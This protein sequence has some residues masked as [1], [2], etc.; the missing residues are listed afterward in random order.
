VRPPGAATRRRRFCYRRDITGYQRSER[1]PVFLRLPHAEAQRLD[2]ASR[3]LGT[4]KNRLIAD[5]VAAHLAADDPPAAIGALK[6]AP[7]GRA[8]FGAVDE[9]EVLTLEQLAAL[10]SLEVDA[11]RELAEAGE[12]PGRKL[13]EEWRF[14][15]RAILAWLSGD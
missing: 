7:I 12:L 14:S 10:L 3:R 1:T 9:P 8:A 15:R 5:L 11:T 2:E 13:G 4:P 6:G